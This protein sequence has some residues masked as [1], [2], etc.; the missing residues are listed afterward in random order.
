MATAS[1]TPVMIVEDYESMRALIRR[2]L[3]SMGFDDIR[4]AAN[5]IQALFALGQKPAG[6]VISDLDMP[7]MTGL[8][9]LDHVRSEPGMADTK[10]IILSGSGD[11]DII[12]EAVALG[13][14]E[15]LTKPIEPQ[16]LRDAVAR[17]LG[18]G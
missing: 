9:L 7:G 11:R 2:C 10:F 4:T 8:E 5:P 12:R 15:Y 13:V 3:E 16:P 1:S 18:E 6:L 17:A 14:D